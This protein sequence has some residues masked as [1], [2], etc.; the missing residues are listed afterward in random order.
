MCVL[1]AYNTVVAL[2][3]AMNLCMCM[4]RD[5]LYTGKY[6]VFCKLKKWC[7]LFHLYVAFMLNYIWYGWS[8]SSCIVKLKMKLEKIVFTVQ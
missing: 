8:V 5:N 3:L 2:E 4:M 6:E 1:Y 7:V